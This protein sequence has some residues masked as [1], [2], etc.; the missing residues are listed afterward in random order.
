MNK[1]DDACPCGSGL[2]LQQCCLPVIQSDNSNS[3]EQLM[4]S[5]YTAFVLADDVYLLNTW[6]S[7]TRPEDF[8]VGKAAWLGLQILESTTDTVSFE[9]AFH[10]GSKGMLLQE[11]SRFALEG[12]HWRYIDGDCVVTPIR[13]NAPCFCGSGIKFKRCCGLRR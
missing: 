7:S 5:R 10:S 2:D 9:A 12:G 11:K 13:R 4:R 3:A 1:R 6:H 8:S